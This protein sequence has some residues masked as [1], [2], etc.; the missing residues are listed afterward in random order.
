MRRT[1]AIIAVLALVALLTAAAPAGSMSLNVVYGTD[2]N[3]AIVATSAA[4]VI[5][6]KSG[7][8]RITGVGDGDV[9]WASSGNDTIS[10]LAGAGNLVVEANVGHDRIEGF[11]VHD[12][13]VNGG[14]GNDSI[15]LNGCSNDVQ[16]ESG[17]DVYENLTFCPSGDTANLGN[18][19]DKVSLS[20]ASS[21]LLGNGNDQLNAITA[22]YVHSSSGNDKLTMQHAAD[23]VVYLGTGHDEV[24]MPSAGGVTLFGSDGNDKVSVGSGADN[25]FHGQS[26]N[27]TFTLESSTGPNA[28]HGDQNRDKARLGNVSGTSCYLIETIVDLA[29]HASSCS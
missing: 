1:G 18:G 13:H 17:N 29:H 25:V 14:S 5:Y 22:D 6:A 3:D 19:H 21:I 2:G 16:G 7:N 20:Y 24:T 27:D 11:G 28:L 10:I 9:V 8:D 4:D 26:G 15:K 23:S 12:S